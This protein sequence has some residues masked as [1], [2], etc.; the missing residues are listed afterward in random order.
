MC[1]VNVLLR[2]EDS[3]NIRNKTKLS[4]SPISYN[5]GSLSAIGLNERSK[6]DTHKK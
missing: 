1:D 2:A 6:W 4:L 3:T 5:M